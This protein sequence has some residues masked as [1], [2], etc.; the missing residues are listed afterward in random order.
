MNK[1]KQ[2]QKSLETGYTVKNKFDGLR[3]YF[4]RRFEDCVAFR[5]V[6]VVTP[7]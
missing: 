3:R 7:L 1:I 4:E 6:K 5:A 2:L